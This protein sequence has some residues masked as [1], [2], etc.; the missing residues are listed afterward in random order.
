MTSFRLDC[1]VVVIVYTSLVLA[2]KKGAAQCS[3]YNSVNFEMVKYFF[4]LK[5][6]E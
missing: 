4:F 5:M 6:G 3:L 1:I 2:V